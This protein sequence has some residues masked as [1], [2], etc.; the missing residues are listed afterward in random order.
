[1]L[2]DFGG[3]AKRNEFRVDGKLILGYGGS[4][5]LQSPDSQFS[6]NVHQLLQVSESKYMYIFKM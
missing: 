5:S 1:M 4:E 3:H 2:D 6:A